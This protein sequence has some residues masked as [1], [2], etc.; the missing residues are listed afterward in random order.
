MYPTV[1]NSVPTDTSVAT[2]A[3]TNSVLPVT[4]NSLP[5]K[6]YRS[7]IVPVPILVASRVPAVP[8][9]LIGY[10]ALGS[11]SNSGNQFTHLLASMLI[12]LPA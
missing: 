8:T 9:K 7:L 11:G 1:V 2:V 4:T 10:F 5:P 3:P 12:L 6:E